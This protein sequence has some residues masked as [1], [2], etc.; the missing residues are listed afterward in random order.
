MNFDNIIERRMVDDGKHNLVLEISA[1]EY[2]KDYDEYNKDYALNI[3]E[4]HLEYRGDDGKPVDVDISYDGE[5]NIVRIYAK[6]EY[7]GNDHTTYRFR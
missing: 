1:D 7:L 2:K 3:L 4:R 6:V 5:S